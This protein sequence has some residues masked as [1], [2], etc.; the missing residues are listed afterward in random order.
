MNMNLDIIHFIEQLG[1]PAAILVFLAWITIKVGRFFAPL[2]N[3]LFQ[4]HIDLM[5]AL[6]DDASEKT[7]ILKSCQIMLQKC[8]ERGEEHTLVLTG[9]SEKL[10]ENLDGIR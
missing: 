3:N 6:R 7:K 9:L 8:D 2:I 10:S 5:Q 1:W 4:A